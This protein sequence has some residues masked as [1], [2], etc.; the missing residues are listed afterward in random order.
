MVID[1]T[2]LIFTFGG[3]IAVSLGT[4]WF[5]LVIKRYAARLG[6]AATPYTKNGGAHI[7]LWGGAPHL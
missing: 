7:P 2:F 3:A 1:T 6:I 4:F 5:A